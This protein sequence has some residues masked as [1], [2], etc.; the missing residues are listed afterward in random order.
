MTQKIANRRKK[1]QIDA[2][3]YLVQSTGMTFK[4]SAIFF[5]AKNW[6]RD[7]TKMWKPQIN[8]R[9]TIRE[10]TSVYGIKKIS[11]PKLWELVKDCRVAEI[12]QIS[13]EIKFECKIES[14]KVLT[15]RFARFYTNKN[16]QNI[17]HFWRTY[18]KMPNKRG[19][20]NNRGDGKNPQNQ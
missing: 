14:S 6:R 17:Q 11:R 5:F 9:Q 20:P 13:R 3:P 19:G 1:L 2:F 18:S 8:T 15:A 7:D 4:F 10:K 16:H 12:S